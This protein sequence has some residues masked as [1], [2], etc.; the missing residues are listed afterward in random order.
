MEHQSPLIT[1]IIPTYCRPKLLKRAIL[2]VLTQTFP[3]FQ[4]CV[5]DNASGDDTKLVVSELAKT[6]TRIKY[7]RHSENIGAAANFNY[8]LTKVSTPFFSFLSDDDVLLPNFFEAAMRSFSTNPDA[9]FYAGLTVMIEDGK[10]V[11]VAKENGPF[12]Y[13]SPPDGLMEILSTG[14][15]IWTSIVFRSEV[16]DHVGI[17][18]TDVGGQIDS[19]YELRIAAHY[20]IIISNEPSAIY[21]HHEQSLS[22]TTSDCALLWPGYQHMIDKIMSD[23]RLSLD[24][25]IQAQ[26]RLIDWL[27]WNL[28]VFGERAINNKDYDNVYKI[29]K[30]LMQYCKNNITSRLL[31]FLSKVREASEGAYRLISLMRRLFIFG[32]SFQSILADKKRLKNLQKQYGKYIRDLEK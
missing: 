4:V 3:A 6:D 23:D 21:A 11:N 18:D 13:F 20:P 32:T 10:I 14:G 25:R 28:R 16:R 2:S 8:G 24:V 12:G 27:H 17:L 19:D 22:T 9:M 31:F 30:L 26:N 29:S 7:Y 15:L 5:Y 1:A